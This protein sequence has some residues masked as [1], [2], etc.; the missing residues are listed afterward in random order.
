MAV[1]V[2]GTAE[3]VHTA[4]L[5]MGEGFDYRPAFSLEQ[6]RASLRPAP[7]LIVCSMRFDDARMIEFLQGLRED[8]Q[9]AQLPVVCF[10]AHGWEV[11]PSAHEAMQEMLESFGN[12]RFVDLFGIAR[13][14]G[15]PAAAA[16]LRQAVTSAYG[17]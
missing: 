2:A 13:S 7:E 11:S 12:A 8:E 10:H 4:R 5:I 9:C 3:A 14:R 16:A 15:V 6:A 1:L 17:G